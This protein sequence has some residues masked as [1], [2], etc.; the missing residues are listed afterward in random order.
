MKKFWLVADL[1]RCVGC[2]A[3]EVICKQENNISEGFP[4][5]RVVE[6]GPDVVHGKLVMDF[7]PLV[8]GECTICQHT[9]LNGSE[10]FCVSICPTNAL[11]FL[12]S[13]GILEELRSNKRIQVLNVVEIEKT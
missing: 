10:P 11:R 6:V 7:V 8:S 9:V 5:I 1:Y 3:C 13:A 4:L 12:E 2:H